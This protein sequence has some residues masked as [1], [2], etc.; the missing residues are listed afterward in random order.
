MVRIS[1]ATS[2]YISTNVR[3]P[4]AR[5]AHFYTIGSNLSTKDADKKTQIEHLYW[6]E[7]KHCGV[8]PV[9]PLVA[10]FLNLVLRYDPKLI[11]STLRL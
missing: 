4:G 1:A 7:F 8:D 9:A 3:I 10:Q 2:Q 5:G 6:Q 11:I